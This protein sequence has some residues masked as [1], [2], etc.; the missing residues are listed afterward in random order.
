MCLQCFRCRAPLRTSP[1]TFTPPSRHSA[2]V[3]NSL[4]VQSPPDRLFALTEKYAEAVVNVAR[5]V[6]TPVLNLFKQMQVRGD[7]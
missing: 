7:V 6:N 2:P 3:E 4:A 5:E 1:P